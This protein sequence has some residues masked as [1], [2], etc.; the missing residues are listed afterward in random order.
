MDRVPVVSAT[1]TGRTIASHVGYIQVAPP[2]VL[3]PPQRFIS[4]LP[5][6]NQCDMGRARGVH[7]LVSELG[8]HP[9]EEFSLWRAHSINSSENLG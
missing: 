5:K 3:Q 9:L 2:G 6:S 1:T 7:A 8:D 4:G